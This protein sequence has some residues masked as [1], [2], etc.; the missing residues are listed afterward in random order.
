MSFA[1]FYL[2][3]LLPAT[4]VN[5]ASDFINWEKKKYIHH[6]LVARYVCDVYVCGEKLL[7][8]T[9]SCKGYNYSNRSGKKK[10]SV[11]KR[12]D[13]HT[14]LRYHNATTRTISLKWLW[15]HKGL[16][17]A[18]AVLRWKMKRRVESTV[19]PLSCL[20]DGVKGVNKDLRYLVILISRLEQ[21]RFI[22][23]RFLLSVHCFTLFDT[24][25]WIFEDIFYD[26][27][28]FFL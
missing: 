15:R 9:L 16:L 6:C 19:A 12:N 21:H 28:T 2:R 4:F 25:C 5:Y 24:F 26:C 27:A 3:L 1:E 11:Q 8:V 7:F 10:R 17:P 14:R 20:P 23:C 13:L 22:T 18:S